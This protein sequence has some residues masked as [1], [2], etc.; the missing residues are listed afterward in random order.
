M[1]KQQLKLIL[2]ERVKT[3]ILSFAEAHYYQNIRN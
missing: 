3:L 1:S 2:E